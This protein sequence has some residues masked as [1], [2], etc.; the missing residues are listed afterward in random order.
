MQKTIIKLNGKRLLRCSELLDIVVQLVRTKHFMILVRFLF[1]LVPYGIISL[2][3]FFL[4]LGCSINRTR[5]VMLKRGYLPLYKGYL[6][7][8]FMLWSV[9]CINHP[10]EVVQVFRYCFHNRVEMMSNVES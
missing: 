10:V 2:R 9:A 4:E 5:V 7:P 1:K 6:T 3:L 8:K